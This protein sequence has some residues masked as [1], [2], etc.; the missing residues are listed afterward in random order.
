MADHSEPMIGA[1]A[2]LTDWSQWVR[3][4][5]DTARTAPTTPG[6]YA[7]RQA[8]QL[9]YVG[10]A[11]ERNG[12]GLRGRLSIYVSGRAPH[13]G[14]GN[15]ALERALQDAVWLR[16]RLAQVDAGEQLTVQQ[17]SI[18]AVQRAALDVCWSSTADAGQAVTLERAVLDA[19]R[20]EPLWNRLR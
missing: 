2:A 1:V 19:V 7:F 12:K 5:A 14:L 16:G 6:V 9:V 10:R 11:G 4:T 17:W 20:E 15:L 8:S 3:F 13:S 18:L